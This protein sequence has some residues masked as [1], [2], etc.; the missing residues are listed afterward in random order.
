MFSSCWHNVR[1]RRSDGRPSTRRVE[2]PRYPP[3]SLPGTQLPN[4]Q[5]SNVSLRLGAGDVKPR[6]WMPIGSRMPVRSSSPPAPRR[7]SCERLERGAGVRTWRRSSYVAQEFVRGAGART[8]RRSSYVAQELVRGA[9]V[10]TWR[11]SSYVAQDFSPA[12]PPSSSALRRVSGSRFSQPAG[13]SGICPD[14]AQ[15]AEM[16]GTEGLSYCEAAAGSRL[17]KHVICGTVNRAFAVPGA[18][19]PPSAHAP[20]VRRPPRPV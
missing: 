12:N 3:R 17:D 13:V 16:A 2:C 14:P 15:G 20:S 10:R 4:W 8:W 1:S 9:G 11:R 7:S 18:T 5:N 19:I 6:I